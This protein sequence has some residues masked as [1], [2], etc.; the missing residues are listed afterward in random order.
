[1]IEG[2]PELGIEKYAWQHN[3]KRVMEE[4]QNMLEEA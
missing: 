1:M 4:V 3:A 2:L